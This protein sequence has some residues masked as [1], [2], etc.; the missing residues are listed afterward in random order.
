MKQSELMFGI[1][2][3]ISFKSQVVRNL[4]CFFF[5]FTLQDIDSLLPLRNLKKRC[6]HASQFFVWALHGESVSQQIM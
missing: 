5:G 2:N 6:L 3:L 1:L 4:F